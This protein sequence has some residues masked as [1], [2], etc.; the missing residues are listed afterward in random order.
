VVIGIDGRSG[1]GK[2]TT[3]DSLCT[4]A[5][6]SAERAVHLP[7]D[8]IA[9]WQA[10]FDWDHLL[11]EH[12]LR[13]VRAGQAVHWRPPAWI[14]RG[15]PGAIEVPADSTML[16][17][18]G[19]GAGRRSL[20]PLLDAIIW[21]QSD[22]TLAFERGIIRDCALHNRSRTEA[23]NQWAEWMTE[24]IPHLAA[25]RPWERADLVLAGTDIGISVGA[26]DLVVAA[27]SLAG[28]INRRRLPC[29]R[30]PD[31]RGTP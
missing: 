2:T 4:A 26:E 16:F 15:R 19:V 10:R 14:S 8:D 20:A 18:E 3:A 17:L 9:W 21:V 12:V 24:E 5:R 28:P 29:G 23:E 25:D 22:N 7:T 6:E 11:L 13:P 31:R 27:Q 1:S 30:R